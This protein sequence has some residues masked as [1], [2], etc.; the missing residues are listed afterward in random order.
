MAAEVGAVESCGTRVPHERRRIPNSDR[1]RL[2]RPLAHPYIP[3]TDE[4]RATILSRLGIDSSEQLFADIPGEFR[5]PSIDLEPQLSEQELVNEL[6]GLAWKNVLPARPISFL[7][8]GAYR[9]YTPA[10]VSH[11]VNRGE[12]KTAYTPYQP[13]ISQGTLQTAFEFQSMVCELTGMDV[14][15]TSM[16]DGASALA[17]ACLMAANVTGRRRIALLSTLHMSYEPVVRTYGAG[18]DLVIDVFDPQDVQLTPEHAC[19]AVQNPNFYGCFE[20]VGALSGMAREAGALYIVS[21]DPISMAMF[22]APADYGADVVVAEGQSLGIPPSFG[23]PY[24]G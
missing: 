3:N 16:Y 10:V 23:G 24:L 4:D 14:A 7:G 8:A 2:R 11:I 6:S 9:H 17:E 18:K 15:N 12:F 19:L 22:R 13:E 1:R 5:D 20:D 21:A